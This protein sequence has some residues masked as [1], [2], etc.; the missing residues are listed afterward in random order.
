[1]SALL[2]IALGIGLG[3]VG[4]YIFFIYVFTDGFNNWMGR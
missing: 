4:F 3:V 2:W 1:M